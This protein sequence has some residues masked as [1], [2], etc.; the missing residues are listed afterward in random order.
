MK[1]FI[2]E[3]ETHYTNLI[4]D[5]KELEEV[6]NRKFGG[7]WFEVEFDYSIY[8]SN[9][10]EPQHGVPAYIDFDLT[11]DRSLFTDEENEI[12]EG[13]REEMEEIVMQEQF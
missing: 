4:E 12:L 8:D 11:W 13:K 2:P 1:L 3:F 10:G 5:E 6:L 7:D 9:G